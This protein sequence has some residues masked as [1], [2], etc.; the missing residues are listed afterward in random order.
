VIARECA[1]TICV[2]VP[3]LVTPTFVSFG[4]EPAWPLMSIWLL[5]MTRLLPVAAGEPSAVL[6]ERAAW[7]AASELTSPAPCSKLG[8]PRSVAVLVSSSRTRAGDGVA[9][10]WVSR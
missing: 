7:T 6:I 10:P 5:S 9:P 8:K 4:V 3:A 1:R 2:L